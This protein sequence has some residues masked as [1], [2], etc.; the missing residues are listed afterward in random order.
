MVDL[1]KAFNRVDHNLVIEDLYNMKCPSFLLKLIFSYLSNRTLIV[2]YDGV[3]ADPQPMPGSG[4]QGTVL[5]MVVFTVK[6]N[7]AC[8]RPPIPRNLPQRYSK[9]IS[10]KYFDDA[11]M[12][13]S[14]NLK[15]QLVNDPVDRIRPHQYKES[16]QLILPEENNVLQSYINDLLSFT[17]ANKMMINKTKDC[18]NDLQHD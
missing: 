5:G 6:F 11:T 12:A 16:N 13:A 7:S 2:Q 15:E 17:I 18:C 10:V 4:P 8:L 1:S 14:I 3:L 9:T